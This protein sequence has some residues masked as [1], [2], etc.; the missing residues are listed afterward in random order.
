MATPATTAADFCTL[1]VKSKLLPAQEVE[2]HYKK[3]KEE[4]PGSDSRVGSF[5]RFL[6]R[7]RA[8]TEYQA[9]LVQSGHTDGFFLGE[10]KILDQVGKGH[11]GGVYKTVHN[12]GQVVAL[13]ILPASKAKNSH[14]LGR[15]QREA[16]LLTQL[17][18][19]NVV[20]AFHVGES[21]GINFIVMEYLEGETLDQVLERRKRLPVYEAARIMC[22]TLDGLQHLHEQRMIHRD[23]KPA[24][25]MLTPSPEA[26]KPDTT[27]NATVKILDIGL[28]RELFDE[29]VQEG[30]VETQLT[31]EGAVLGTPDYLAPEQAKDA[32]A[33]DIR[34]DIYSVGCVLYHCLAGRPLFPEKNIMTQMV[35][36]A[37]EQPAP[38]SATVQNLPAGFQE[39]IDRFL[40]KSPDE[41]F[42]TPADA[43][44]A[45][46]SFAL[47]GSPP[48]APSTTVPAF[49]SW[50]AGAQPVLPQPVKA[51]TAVRVPL[52]AVIPIPAVEKETSD[53]EIDVELVTTEQATP[54][55]LAPLPVAPTKR[56]VWPL[57]RR[58]WLMLA[59][60]GFGVLSAVGL[61]YGLARLLRK[62]DAE[63]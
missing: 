19:P 3:W 1:L 58:D 15:F 38:L 26:G 53:A 36:H 52:P 46:Q 22:Q 61:G 60:G 10:Y 47:G 31:A 28:G 51:G 21:G 5:R 17:E 25:L 23:L 6:I 59:T 54:P 14:L 27:W 33:A 62:K 56:P 43:A 45:L 12:S 2:T 48:A 39:L 8:L 44:T 35:K 63:E 9:L 55:A 18:H 7:N 37:T 32:R 49:Q 11:M 50:L 40:A 16:R 30:Q 42:Q 24:N 34:S 20:R 57:D 41:R 29:D 13:K 4:R